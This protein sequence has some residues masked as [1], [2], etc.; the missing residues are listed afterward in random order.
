M[1]SMGSAK[2]GKE[3][4]VVIYKNG[5]SIKGAAVS[6]CCLVIPFIPTFLH[7]G[8]PSWITPSS[9]YLFGSK[10]EMGSRLPSDPDVFCTRF[11]KSVIGSCQHFFSFC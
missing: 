1:K 11:S 2:T 7:P 4:R 9:D 5:E 6:E 3:T 10:N 8:E